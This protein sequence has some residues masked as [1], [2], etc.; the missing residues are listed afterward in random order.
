[1]W[2]VFSALRRPVTVL[3]VIVAVVLCAVLAL[4]GMSIDIFPDLG[5]PAIYVIQPYGG[6]APSQMEAYLVSFYE[7]HVLYI[8]GIEH[9]ESKSIQG[10]A[11]IK[12]FF[13]PGTDMNQALAQ[14]VAYIDRSRAFMPPG[15][16]PPGHHPVRRR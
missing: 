4:S 3:V 12:L 5:L 6:M 2:M 14:T 16:L 15:T 13:Y 7:Y 8:L 9:V 11:L 10:A 1:M